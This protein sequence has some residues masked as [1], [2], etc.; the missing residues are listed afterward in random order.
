ME[1]GWNMVKK[2]EKRIEK[3]RRD[4]NDKRSE[5]FVK[6]F[7]PKEEEKRGGMDRRK[8]KSDK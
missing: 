3:D 6:Y 4:S 5:D 1:M 8:S 7:L 2:K